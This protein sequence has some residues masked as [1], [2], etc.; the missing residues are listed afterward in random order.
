MR[1]R[2]PAAVVRQC[3]IRQAPR[4]AWVEGPGFGAVRGDPVKTVARAAETTEAG[5][6]TG[7]E[8]PVSLQHCSTGRDDQ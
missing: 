6:D 7:A 5:T 4:D 3:R 1:Q 8:A 2:G